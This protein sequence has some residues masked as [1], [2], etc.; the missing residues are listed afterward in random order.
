LVIVEQRTVADLKDKKRATPRMLV[1][2]SSTDDRNNF[3]VLD[4]A[5]YISFHGLHLNGDTMCLGSLPGG[6]RC[7]NGNKIV[8]DVKKNQ[9]LRFTGRMT[10]TLFLLF[11]SRA[12]SFYST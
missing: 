10:T 7:V 3:H 12:V 9:V 5:L 11:V 1:A 4:I 2:T 6:G 8:Q